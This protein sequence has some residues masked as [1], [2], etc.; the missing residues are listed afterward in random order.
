MKP[1]KKVYEE[2]M[3]NL[4]EKRNEYLE[5]LN[6]EQEEIMNFSEDSP[7]LSKRERI[8]ITNQIHKSKILGGNLKIDSIS[9]ALHELGNVLDSCGFYLDMVS[10]D[11]VDGPEG[12]ALLTFRRKTDN[13]YIQGTEIESSRISFTWE[14]LEPMED[15]I[16]IKKRYEIIAYLT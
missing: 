9:K 3:S 2:M 14:N 4:L 7:K 10:G 11:M 15:G 16:E 1:I 8:K 13:P 12:N 5:N 6:E